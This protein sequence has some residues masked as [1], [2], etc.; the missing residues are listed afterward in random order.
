M[1]ERTEYRQ[2]VQV[3][4]AALGVNVAPSPTGGVAQ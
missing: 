2:L 4:L 1:N 3:K